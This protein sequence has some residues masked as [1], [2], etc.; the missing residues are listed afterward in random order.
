M[1][2]ITT[3]SIA[4]TGATVK[5][6]TLTNAE[7]DNNFIN[8]NVDIQTRLLKTGGTNLYIGS[9]ANSTR[10][11]NSVTVFSDVAS[12]IQKN[13]S[14]NIGLVSEKTGSFLAKTIIAG[15]SGGTTI[16]L[17]DVTGIY[18]GQVVSATG[19]ASEAIITNIN[20]GT[21]VITLSI[22]NAGTPSG[23][24]NIIAYGVGAY[25]IGYTSG[26]CT[27]IGLIGEAHV[28]I[29]SASGRAI[30]VKGY[31]SDT[32]ASGSN[33]GLYGSAKNGLTNYS[34]Y[35]NDGDIYSGTGNKTWHLN[36]NL[37]FS[38]GGGSYSITIP[39]LVLGTEL[40][41]GQGGTGA[42]NSTDAKINLGLVIGTHVQAYNAKL[43]TLAALAFTESSFIVGT[44]TTWQIESGATA[45]TSLGLGSIATQNSNNIS[46]TGGSLSGI[47]SIGV[48]TISATSISLVTA[49]TTGDGG[50][51]RTTI[52]TNGQVLTSTGTA[53]TYI[54]PSYVP[55]QT[56]F[57]GRYLKTNGTTA[58]WDVLDIASPDTIG[59]LPVTKGGTGLTS[60]LDNG[61]IVGNGANSIGTIAPGA[62]KRILRSDGTN[63]YSAKATGMVVQTVSNKVDTKATYVF[64][65]AGNLGTIINVLNTAITTSYASSKILVQFNIS[66]EVHHDTVFRLF[67][68]IAG[69]ADVEIGRNTTDTGYW[70]GIWLPG[71]DNDNDSTPR[72]NHYMY[73]DS[74]N[75]ASG[76]AL[77]YKLMI[78]SAGVASRTFYL[79]RSITA[80]GQNNYE[81]ATS[82]VLLQEIY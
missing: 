73:M 68:E 4:G 72:T 31:S 55:P 43:S 19:V 82:T 38:N 44:G 36:S 21:N 74:P 70:S 50:T 67:R 51:G 46:I 64:A 42:T 40:A 57:S 77:I 69:G 24:A 81:V 6:S 66:F 29:S 39:Q 26:G 79:N 75:C 63:W 80:S 65:T 22:A 10:F 35:L 20:T 9:Q 32:H 28:N 71:Y 7:V 59:T 8:L 61:L 33:I 62:T 41:I 47:T 15:S 12:G 48:T 76:Y 49:L 45:R 1:A 25:G 2:A 37:T 14:H 23:T 3:R 54:T 18:I 11:P 53:L 30:G 56:T 34:L 60:I 5:N 16:T 27:G 78:Q 13:E 52:G 58:S 17:S